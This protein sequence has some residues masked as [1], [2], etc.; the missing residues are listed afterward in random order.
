MLDRL[1][2]LLG[3][4]LFLIGFIVYAFGYTDRGVWDAE[5]GIVILLGFVAWRAVTHFTGY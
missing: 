4:A 2:L 1:L 5:A 3:V